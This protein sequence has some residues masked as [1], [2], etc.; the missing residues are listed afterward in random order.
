MALLPE[1]PED[2]EE[3]SECVSFDVIN[4]DWTY[5]LVKIG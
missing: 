4:N 3:E 5:L 1:E 2:E